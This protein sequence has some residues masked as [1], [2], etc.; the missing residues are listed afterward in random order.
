ME[1]SRAL[2]GI[3]G[4]CTETISQSGKVVCMIIRAGHFPKSTT[5]YTQEEFS[6]QVGQVVHPAGSEIP[7]HEHRR[8]TRTVVGTPEVLV[9][10][11]GRLIVDL[12]AE[13][14]RRLLCS[15]ELS[16]GDVIVLLTGGHGFHLIEETVLL[17]VKQGPYYGHQ[18]KEQ[19]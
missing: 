5:F 13:D 12:Y 3:S 7:R 2:T 14:D 19:F 16:T 1:E 9:V 4:E 10:Q 8:T 17:E 18:E 6:F 11:R 15:R